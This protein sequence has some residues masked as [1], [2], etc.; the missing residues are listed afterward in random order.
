MRVILFLILLSGIMPLAEAWWANRATSLVQA[1]HWASA[2]WLA[3]LLTLVAA[4]VP[5]SSGAIEPAPYLALCLTG[6]AGVAVLGA[7][8]PHVGGWNFVVL[9]LLAIMVWPLAEGLVTG[10]P[11]DLLQ[12]VFLAATLGLGILNYLPTRLAPAALFLAL[13]CGGQII[14]LCRPDLDAAQLQAID[15]L[16]LSCLAMAPWLGRWAWR[17]SQR[18]AAEF[19]RLWLDFRNRYG[20]VWSQRIRDQFNRSAAHAGWTVHLY[21]QGLY[22]TGRAP[23]PD[24]PVQIEMLET[25]RALLKRFG[26]E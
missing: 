5:D 10:A 12:L 22:L 8:R 21:W 14:L 6:C 2:A 9:A 15:L 17:R 13:G 16:A 1:I 7:R 11:L 4:P 25:L 3:W 24:L 19:D 23:R 20:F 26:P 18:P